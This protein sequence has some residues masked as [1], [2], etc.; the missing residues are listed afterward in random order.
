VAIFVLLFSGKPPTT[1]SE[2]PDPHSALG[3]RQGLNEVFKLIE[4]YDFPRATECIKRLKELY[5]TNIRVAKHAYLLAKLDP[6]S[7]SFKEDLDAYI[8]AISLHD[9][10][11]SAK[12]LLAELVQT[13]RDEQIDSHKVPS[14]IHLFA[15]HNDLK[16][17]ELSFQLYQKIENREPLINEAKALLYQEFEKRNLRAK[18]SQYQAS[19]AEPTSP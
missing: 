5:P 10:Y 13:S 19:S 11:Y 3:V 2:E 16:K 9:D 17:A 1:Q 7:S 15:S 8:V 18:M 14:L 4:E 12:I 6:Q